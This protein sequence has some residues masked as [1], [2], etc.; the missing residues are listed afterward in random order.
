MEGKFVVKTTPGTSN[1]V[2][3]EMKLEQTIPCSKK[4]QSGIIG[5]TSMEA[6]VTEW[7]LVYHEVLEISNAFAKLTKVKSEYSEVELPFHHE[8]SG[9]INV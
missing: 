7:E 9:S 4:S 1:A 6:Y 5:Q 8:L 3:P 2:S